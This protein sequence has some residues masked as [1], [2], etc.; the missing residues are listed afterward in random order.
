MKSIRIISLLF[1]LCILGCAPYKD[2]VVRDQIE[3]RVKNIG[4]VVIPTFESQLTGRPDSYT[5]ERKLNKELY[6]SSSFSEQVKGAIL[7]PLYDL[8]YKNVYYLNT[9]SFMSEAAGK[10]ISQVIDLVKSNIPDI[11]AVLFMFWRDETFHEGYFGYFFGGSL[12]MYAADSKNA[13]WMQ[14]VE[15]TPF[16]IPK[17]KMIT[18]KK[19]LR[20]ETKFNKEDVIKIF[21]NKIREVIKSNIPVLSSA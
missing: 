17:E 14:K 5:I 13:L 7:G 11:D 19:W 16:E 4:V 1:V 2:Y 20:T 21:L 9:S 12:I 3:G 8:H 10:T 18:T 6:L 15:A